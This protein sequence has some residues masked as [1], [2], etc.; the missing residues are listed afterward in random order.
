MVPIMDG[1]VQNFAPPL[2]TPDDA[3]DHQVDA[4]MLLLTDH[5]NSIS[6]GNRGSQA[7]GPFIPR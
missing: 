5:G 1:S 6:Y 7:R 3:I 2:G 4:V